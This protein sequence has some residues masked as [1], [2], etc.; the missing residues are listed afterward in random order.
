[1]PKQ[2]VKHQQQLFD[3]SQSKPKFDQ[4]QTAAGITANTAA[5]SAGMRL[6][7]KVVPSAEDALARLPPAEG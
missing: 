7:R 4:A 3:L 2:K 1:M 5:G 6:G